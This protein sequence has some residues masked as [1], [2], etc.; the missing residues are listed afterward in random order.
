[1]AGAGDRARAH[2]NPSLT[3]PSL[4]PSKIFAS[5]ACR[6]KPGDVPVLFPAD[7]VDKV[8]CSLAGSVG[9][10]LRDG[11]TNRRAQKSAPRALPMVALVG[12]ESITVFQPLNSH[13]TSQCSAMDTE[14]VRIM[15]GAKL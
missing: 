3:T 14:D 11:V 12:G 1:M 5:R 10:P 13:A 15:D 4:L 8:P 9:R 2:H 7:S 6:M